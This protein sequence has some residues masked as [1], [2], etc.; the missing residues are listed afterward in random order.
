[1]SLS[2]EYWPARRYPRDYCFL[3]CL[4]TNEFKHGYE[5]SKKQSEDLEALQT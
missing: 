3:I 4:V 5:Y 1:M 2:T